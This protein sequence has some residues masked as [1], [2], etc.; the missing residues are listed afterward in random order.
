MLT[1]DDLVTATGRAPF[2][3]A[4]EAKSCWHLPLDRAAEVEDLLPWSAVEALVGGR[5]VPGASLRVL[6]GGNELARTSY[7]DGEGRLRPDVVQNLA[8]Q[9]ATLAINAIDAVVPVLGQ[10]AAAMERE[11]RYKIGV[12]GYLTF[13]TGSAFAAHGDAHDVLVLQLH[14]AKRWRRFGSPF[15]FP[16]HSTRPAVG[17]PIWEAVLRPGDL[18]FLPRGEVHAALPETRP[19]V[20]L[21]FALQEPTGVDLVQWLA[22]RAAEVETLRRGLA[23]TLTGDARLQR[24]RELKIA[25]HALVDDATIG[26]FLGDEDRARTLRAVAP[27]G[28]LRPPPLALAPDAIVVAALRRP[29]DLATGQAGDV[30]LMLGNRR[31]RLSQL[32]RRA[33]NELAVRGHLSLAALA[34]SLEVTLPDSDFAGAIAELVRESLIAPAARSGG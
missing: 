1:L 8:A 22:T 13:G 3:A 20:H 4:L 30:L 26:A 23:P 24:E 14:G 16:V 18:L 6:V 27:L 2:L 33:L 25:L 21:T 29:L 10:L 12:N 11:L 17:D 32:A 34:Q 5:L 28:M 15:A 31:I 9:G 19:S 7:C